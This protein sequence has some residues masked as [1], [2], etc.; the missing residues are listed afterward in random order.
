MP[1]H[2][3]LTAIGGLGRTAWRRYRS[4]PGRLEIS[5]AASR[6]G[7]GR[8]MGTTRIDAMFTYVETQE[9]DE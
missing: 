5:D 9:A 1:V 7:I 3:R 2:A 6:D 8:F 4:S